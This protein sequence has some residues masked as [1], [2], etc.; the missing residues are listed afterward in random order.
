LNNLGYVYYLK[1]EYPQ[2]LEQYGKVIQVAPRFKEAHS[3]LALVYYQLQ[4]YEEALQEIEVVLKMDPNHEAAKKF[5]E[6]IRKKIQ[7]KK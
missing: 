6:T 4:R 2:A 3:N 7:E 5:R 1:K